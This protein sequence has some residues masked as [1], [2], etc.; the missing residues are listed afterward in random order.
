MKRI[1]IIVALLGLCALAGCDK[2]V[3]EPG[4]PRVLFSRPAQTSAAT[5]SSAAARGLAYCS[6][7]RWTWFSSEWS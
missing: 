7:N 2:D 5:R 4:E 3:R 1:S 6:P